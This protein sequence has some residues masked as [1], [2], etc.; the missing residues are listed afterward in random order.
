MAAAQATLVDLLLA[1]RIA[2]Q[3]ASASSILGRITVHSGVADGDPLPFPQPQAQVDVEVV[4]PVDRIESVQLIEVLRLDAE[5]GGGDPA[6]LLLHRE[7]CEP[8]EHGL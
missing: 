6:H 3:G 8:L 1:E 2:Q 5:T 7:R 4:I